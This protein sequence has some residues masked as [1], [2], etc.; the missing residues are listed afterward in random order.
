MSRFIPAI[1]LAAVLALASSGA[2]AT[3]FTFDSSG[4]LTGNFNLDV[5]GDDS[6]T[7]WRAGYGPSGGFPGSDG[8]FVHFNQ[9]NTGNS[10]QFQSGPVFLNSFDISSQWGEGGAGVSNASD[11]ANDYRLMLYDAGLSVIYDQVL[12]IAAGGVW[13]TLTLNVADVSVIRITR[14]SGDGTGT[15]GWW[16]NLDNVTVNATAAPEPTALALMALGLAGAG[17]LRRRAS[18]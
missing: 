3:V 13:E 18:A 5:I 16:P 10:I 8:G 1:A 14:R 11:A 9:Y 17:R 4:D 6:T 2:A 12:T 7:H 15:G